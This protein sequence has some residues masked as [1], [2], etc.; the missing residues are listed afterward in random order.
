MANGGKRKVTIRRKQIP[1]WLVVATLVV[2]AA[3]LASAIYLLFW[4]GRVWESLAFFVASGLSLRIPWLKLFQFGGGPTDGDGS[5]GASG[6]QD[7]A[8]PTV[9]VET[10]GEA[11]VEDRVTEVT[12][13]LADDPPE[14][15]SS[16]ATSRPPAPRPANT[17]P[18]GG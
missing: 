1:L 14:H 15:H 8:A 18:D 11:V 5:S 7:G 17:E 6:A 10:T 4:K 2:A 12:Q 16:D 3:L 13:R 9:G